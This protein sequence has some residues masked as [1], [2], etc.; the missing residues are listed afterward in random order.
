MAIVITVPGDSKLTFKLVVGTNPVSG[1][2][3]LKSKTFSKVK[4]AALDQD[5]YDVGTALMALQKYTVDEMILTKSW[6]LT[7]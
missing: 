3:I 6:L 1:A 2:P 7:E 5:V 4:A